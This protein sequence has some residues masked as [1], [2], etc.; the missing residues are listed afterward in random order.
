VSVLAA[1]VIAFLLRNL[2][3]F[4]I[5]IIENYIFLLRNQ[6]YVQ[7]TSCHVFSLSLSGSP[8]YQ[9]DFLTDVTDFRAMSPSGISWRNTARV[10]QMAVC[11]QV[12]RIAI[13][14]QNSKQ[15]R[16]VVY[17]SY[18]SGHEICCWIIITV[19][20]VQLRNASSSR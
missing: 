15:L 6:H 7:L 2:Y 4:L 9:F 1:K 3:F 20:T 11:K 19:L 8:V 5:C 16:L 13:S 10:Q 18:V 12:P 17:C 14:R